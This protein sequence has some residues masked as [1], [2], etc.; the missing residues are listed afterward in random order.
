[1]K[2][3]I[4]SISTTVFLASC[5]GETTSNKSQTIAND[6][7]KV[8]TPQVCKKGYDKDATEIA[9]GGFKTTEKKEVKGFFKQFTV[10]STKV[11]DTPEEIF[12][13]AE[14]SIP[15]NYLETNDLGRNRRIR[16][17]YFGNMEATENITGKV[18]A[19]NPDSNQVQIELTLNSVTKEIDLN[20]SVNGD[21]IALAGSI[22]ILDFNASAGLEALNKAC[23]AL[24]KGPD[25]VSKTWSDVNLYISSV[26]K[27]TCK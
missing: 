9:F 14:F 22:D 13:N 15:V 3:L 24:H 23:E 19:F 10:K 17:E 7:S 16:D 18:I 25:G 5:G 11:A 6:T 1:M 8:E 2:K 20:Y 4:L 27:E 12:G 21:T 26:I